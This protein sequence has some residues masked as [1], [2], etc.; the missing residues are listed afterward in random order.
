[1]SIHSSLKR[2]KK[3]K[4]SVRKRLER[5]FELIKK[6]IKPETP[7]A[8]PKEKVIKFK[9]KK[10]EKEEKKLEIIDIISIPE[11]KDKKKSKDVGKIK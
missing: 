4:K 6:G 9:V 11:K 10:K 5:Y 3:K 1:M 8:L 7:F 2:N